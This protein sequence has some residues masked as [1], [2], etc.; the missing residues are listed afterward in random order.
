[1]AVSNSYWSTTVPNIPQIRPPLSFDFSKKSFNFKFLSNSTNV[2]KSSPVNNSCRC[3]NSSSDHATSSDWDWNQWTRHF[4]QIELT[5]RSVSLLQVLLHTL[6][7]DFDCNNSCNIKILL[8]LY[9]AS[10]RLKYYCNYYHFLKL[11]LLSVIIPFFRY[12]Q[13]WY[14]Y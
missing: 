10:L 1:M 5:E 4:S 14:T 12:Y 3:S 6:V 13:C 2:I 8:Y 11:S 7:L 9:L